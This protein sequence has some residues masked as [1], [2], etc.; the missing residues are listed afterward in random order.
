MNNSGKLTQFLGAGIWSILGLL[1]CTMNFAAGNSS[2]NKN[3]KKFK[4]GQSTLELSNYNYSNI[5]RVHEPG[6]DHVNAQK[7][8]LKGKLKSRPSKRL[9]MLNLPSLDGEYAA[10]VCVWEAC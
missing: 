6:K 9:V 3:G 7:L 1:F 5:N 4:L 2:R 10:E 8:V